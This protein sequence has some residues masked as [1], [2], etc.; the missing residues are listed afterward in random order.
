MPDGNYVIKY[1]GKTKKCDNETSVFLFKK[2][3][4][5]LEKCV[6]NTDILFNGDE[7]EEILQNE[8]IKQK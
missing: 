3:L 2:Y 7:C 6:K 1:W 5:Y 4:D 8:F